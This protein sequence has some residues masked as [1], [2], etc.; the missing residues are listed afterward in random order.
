LYPVS[1]IQYPVLTPLSQL[2]IRNS[3]FG[4]NFPA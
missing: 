1:C 3:F 4:C 2:C